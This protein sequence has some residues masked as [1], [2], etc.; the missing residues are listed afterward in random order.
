[1]ET[2]KQTK[3]YIFSTI[4][5]V[6]LFTTHVFSSYASALVPDIKDSP[7]IKEWNDAYIWSY[8]LNITTNPDIKEA[9]LKWVLYRKI[10]AKMMAEF[11]INVVHLTPDKNRICNFKDIHKEIDELQYYIQL[12]CQLGIMGVDYYGNPDTIFNPNYVLT[13]DQLV[14]MFSRVLFGT[15]Y[16]IKEGELTFMDRVKN[17]FF[18]SLVNIYTALGIKP[19]VATS[20]DR[21]TK[22]MEAIKKLWI[23]TNYTS[24]LKEFKGYVMVMMYTLDKMGVEKIQKD[25]KNTFEK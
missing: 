20:L 2:L 3:L 19:P 9:N 23:M 24:T 25:D 7:Y 4:L 6:V 17:F 15:K 18:H 10:A 22:H 11:A 8:T 16:N 5:I 21:Y 12:S 14:T 13:R 1:L